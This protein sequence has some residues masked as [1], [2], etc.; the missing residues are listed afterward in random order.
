MAENLDTG[1]I[2]NCVPGWVRQEKMH[3]DVLVSVPHIPVGAG[4]PKS[5]SVQVLLK[6]LLGAVAMATGKW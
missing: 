6:L 1:T 4:S 5:L 2:P 3:T